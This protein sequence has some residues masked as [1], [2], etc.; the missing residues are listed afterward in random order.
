MAAAAAAPSHVDSTDKNQQKSLCL[1]NKIDI[2]NFYFH[3]CHYNRN[4]IIIL[5]EEKEMKLI[6]LPHDCR[7]LAVDVAIKLQVR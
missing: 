2:H 3:C 1:L 4:L 7:R 5:E 6:H